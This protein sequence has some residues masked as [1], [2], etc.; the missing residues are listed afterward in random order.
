MLIYGLKAAINDLKK[1]FAHMR[2]AAFGYSA[3]FNIDHTGLVWRRVKSRK[4]S[5]GFT[6]METTSVTDLSHQLRSKHFADAA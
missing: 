1:S 6:V 4:G 3:G 5:Y 2:G